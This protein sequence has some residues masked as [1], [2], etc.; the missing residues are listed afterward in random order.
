[1]KIGFESIVLDALEE[2]VSFVD[3]DYRYQYVN[4]SYVE[5]FGKAKEEIV[6][7]RVQDLIGEENFFQEVKSRLDKALKGKIV[8]FIN[9]MKKEGRIIYLHM[10]YN[11]QF[12]EKGKVYG[13]VS[14][15]KDI[16][17][18]V[19]LRKEKDMVYNDW[20]NSVN[21]IDDVLMILDP[22]RNILEINNPGLEL[23]HKSREN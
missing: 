13:V 16:T 6:Q 18:Q 8:S 17:D 9:P 11:P 19:I 20:I 1:M 14:I 15:A 2:P 10:R 7:K 4:H 3:C 23:F 22:D 12:N 5:L 21:S